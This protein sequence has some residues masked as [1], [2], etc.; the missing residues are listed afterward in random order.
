MLDLLGHK[1]YSTIEYSLFGAV[2]GGVTS[3]LQGGNFWEGAAIGL[4]VKLLNH[5]GK[6]LY[7][8]IGRMLQKQKQTFEDGI[9]KVLLSATIG[10]KI[11]SKELVSKFNVPK[12]AASL[13]QSFTKLSENSIEVDWISSLNPTRIALSLVSDAVFDDGIIN[14][15]DMSDGSLK[16]TGN[17]IGI[18]FEGRIYYKIFLNGNNAKIPETKDYS[19]KLVNE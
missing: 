12:K 10:K 18:T 14:A 3:H 16:I 9:R 17:G 19:W 1:T 7:P 13:I 4:T 15:T 8:A 11:L 6:K 5:A 2:T